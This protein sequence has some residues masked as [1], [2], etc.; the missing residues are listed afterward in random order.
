MRFK[1]DDIYGAV[2]RERDFQDEK[3]GG[4]EEN[5]HSILEWVTIMER[6]LQEAKEA[7]FQGPTKDVSEDMLSEIVQVVA[8]GIACLDQY[9]YVEGH[10]GKTVEAEEETKT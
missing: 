4:V 5:P 3:W 9:G 1:R 2:N 6:E 8:V 7:W 10:E